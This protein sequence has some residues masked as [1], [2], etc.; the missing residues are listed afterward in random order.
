MVLVLDFVEAFQ[1]CEHTPKVELGACVFVIGRIL[2][3]LM[4][5]FVLL[6]CCSTFIDFVFRV[7]RERIHHD[8]FL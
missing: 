5:C 7:W 2:I 1:S 4:G 3:N 8:A 6:F